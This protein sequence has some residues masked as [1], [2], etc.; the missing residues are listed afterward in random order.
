MKFT[1]IL[2][3]I[4]LFTT[5]IAIGQQSRLANQYYIN[6]E[7]AKAAALYEN[8]YQKEANSEYY[9][10]RYTECLIALK[11]YTKT[12]QVILQE[13]KAHPDDIQL[14]ISLGNLYER[15]AQPEKAD[16]EYANV[17]AALSTSPE[18]IDKVARSFIA[19]NLYSYA[20]DAYKVGAE[21]SKD[22]K[23]YAFNIADLYRRI[24]NTHEMVKYYLLSI[25]QFRNNLNYLLQTFE[26]NL[27]TEDIPVL[28]TELYTLIQDYPE[29]LAYAEILEWTFINQ[30]EYQKAL[31]Q[32][33]ALDRKYEENGGRVYNIANIALNDE[34]YTTAIEAYSYI[35]ER[36]SINTSYYLLAKRSLLNAKRNKITKG[37]NYSKNDL[38]SLEKEYTDFFDFY[39]KNTQTIGLMLEYAEFQAKYMNDL[40]KAKNMLSE[41]ISF[42]GVQPVILAQAK[43]DLGDYHL[44]DGDQWEATLLYSQV[45]KDF[46]EGVLGEQARYR[47]ARLS[48]YTGE[49]QWAQEQFDILK[50]ATTRLISNDAID[51]SVFIMD[52]LNLDTIAE[53]MEMFAKAEMLIF[54]NRLDE[55]IA[56]LDSVAKMYPDHSLQDDIMYVKAQIYKKR[57]QPEM[58]IELYTIIAEK[59]KEEI[60][61]DN[62]L[63]DMARLY[64][65]HFS[66][67]EK[68]KEI[69]LKIFTEYTSSTFA[70]DARKRYRLLRGDNI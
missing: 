9:F 55:A 56:T 27:G 29:E 19:L 47:N 21:I 69:Y 63:Y 25:D 31:R 50:A 5:T 57:L 52:N 54:Q 13:M 34:D 51:M 14:H 44:M 62:A 43:L 42:G 17:I 41:L 64:E 45:D 16:N 37:F 23:K 39:G 10:Q 66:N 18:N 7:Y 46:K 4:L 6:G 60:R 20:V 67:I 70:I 1:T 59:Y 32:A 12:E 15:L 11:E 2:T 40:T 68:A 38:L 53:P 48:Y 22:E 58:A 65:T 36:K 30:K 3:L 33:R 49:F 35:I 8:L 26:R 61:A 24:G 28:Q